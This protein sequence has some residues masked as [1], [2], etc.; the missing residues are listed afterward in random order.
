MPALNKLVKELVRSHVLVVSVPNGWERRPYRDLFTWLLWEKNLLAMGLY[1]KAS[2]RRGDVSYIFTCPPTEDVTLHATDKVFCL[3]PTR[4]ESAGEGDLTRLG[5]RDPLEWFDRL[6]DYV[7]AERSRELGEAFS[8]YVNDD[9]TVAPK[10]FASVLRSQGLS[11]S[12]AE[13]NAMI[14]GAASKEGVGFDEFNDLAGDALE[15]GWDSPADIMKKSFQVIDSNGEGNLDAT[16][17]RLAFANIIGVH[18]D[19]SDCEEL[20]AKHDTNGRGELNFEGWKQMVEP[21][22]NKLASGKKF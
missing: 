11:P 18:L 21:R 16:E 19:Q 4:P 9:G 14:E 17:M 3:V 20:I 12:D 5:K 7:N 13:V 6:V 15:E 8:L 1:R 22:M 2:A 10:D